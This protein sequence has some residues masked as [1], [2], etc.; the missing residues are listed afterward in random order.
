MCVCVTTV[1]ADSLIY[2]TGT[3]ETVTENVENMESTEG[4]EITESTETASDTENTE[5]VCGT[6]TSETALSTETAEESAETTEIEEVQLETDMKG[7]EGIAA[8]KSYDTA[9]ELEF[10]KDY[11]SATKVSVAGWYQ[12]T[13]EK[14]GMVSFTFSHDKLDATENTEAWSIVFAAEKPLVDI[15]IST[16][17]YTLSSGAYDI[18][19]TSPQVG[20]QAGTYRIMVKPTKDVASEKNYTM[21]LNFHDTYCE[22]ETNNSVSDADEIAFSTEV[23]GSLYSARDTD[24]YKVTVTEDGSIQFK[25]THSKVS[26]KENVNLYHIS[27]LDGSEKTLYDMY[28]NGSET[29]KNSINIGATKGTYFLKVEGG[30][31]SNADPYT[32]NYGLTVTTEVG[33]NWEKENND[34]ISV[35]NAVVPGVTYGGDIRS[36]DDVDYFTLTT[37]G[38]GYLGMDFSHTVISGWETLSVYKITVSRKGQSGAVYTGYVKG[39]ETNWAMPNL[40]LPADTYY[41]KL[42]AAQAISTSVLGGTIENGYPA[43]YKITVNWQNATAW[44][45]EVNDTISTANTV[46]SGTTYTGSIATTGDKDYYKVDLSKNGYLQV[47]F[48]HDNTGNTATHYRISVLNK[49]G[50]NIYEVTNAGVDTLYVSDKI[51]LEKGTYY[52]LIAASST[53]YTGDYRL[54]VTTK[55]ASDWESELNGDTATADTLKV[56]K[57]M[58]G[59]ISSYSGDLDYYKFTLD[60]AAYVN[61]SLT[62]RKINAAGRSWYVYLLS[63]SGKRLSYRDTDHLYSYAGA[64]YTESEAVK[65]QKGTYYVVVRT[66]SDNKNAVGEEYT[67]C[68]NKISAKKP[69]ISGVESTA[70]NK[71]KVTWKAVPGATSYTIYRSTSKD[72]GYTEVKTIHDVGTVSWTDSKVTTGKTYYY[73]MKATVAV[74]GGST[75]ESGYSKV[76]SGK[77]VPA[78]TTLKATTPSAKQV[79]LTWKKVSGASGYEIYRS[80]KKDGKYSKIK[81]ITKGSTKTYTDKSKLKSGTTCYY[82]IRAYRKV[83]GKKVYGEYS[84]VISKKVK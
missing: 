67:V 77:P 37:T 4:I 64:A 68:V 56:G 23:T 79:K 72:S 7:A 10:E 30:L 45:E 69:T 27:L 16:G 41:I 61:V 48:E 13:L 36:T 75:K 35:A 66:A 8:G 51:G 47:R 76:K 29:E 62:H 59:I 15:G 21:R 33:G 43:D 49:D 52:V 25:L 31:I 26:G 6:E 73:K 3:K 1:S 84:K 65:L 32:G 78:A 74:E 17:M 82:K 34:T 24:Y 50:S 83:N 22:T 38:K 5:A 81:T 19:T 18:T 11:Q 20:L 42:E 44:E 54:K 55:A 70:Y 46:K 58:N 28:S 12:F 71:L 40:G 39:G 60:K 80:T 9:A 63:A 2:A 57:E 14:P 53:L